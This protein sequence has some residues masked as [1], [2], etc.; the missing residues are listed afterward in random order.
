M[1]QVKVRDKIKR[2]V[3]FIIGLYVNALGV[4]FVTK[5]SRHLVTLQLL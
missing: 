4:A 1:S 3:V 5:A 2:Y